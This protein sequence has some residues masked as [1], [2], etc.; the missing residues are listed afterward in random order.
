LTNKS[1]M[2]ENLTPDQ[3]I[4]RESRL[5]SILKSLSWRIVATL[6]TIALTWFF[7]GEVD[8]ALK[9][10]SFEFVLKF[11]IYYFHERAWQMVPRGTIRQL[12]HRS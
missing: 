5:R 9:V 7:T 8:T 6:T 12:A 2:P 10:G 3:R 4:N 11:L 1:A